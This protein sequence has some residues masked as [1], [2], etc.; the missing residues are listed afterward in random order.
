MTAWL[1]GGG[2]DVLPGPAL[3]G[4]VLPR[5]VRTDTPWLAGRRAAPQVECRLVASAADLV[6]HREIRRTVFV[7]EQ[8][9]FDLTDHDPRDDDPATLHVLGLVAGVPAGTVRLFPVDGARPG[10]PDWQGDRLAVL[11]AFRH[12]GLGAP[13]VR[14]AV[15]TAGALGGRRMLAHVQPPNRTFF[16]RLGWAQCGAPEIYV[17]LP[18]LRMEIDL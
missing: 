9:V 3:P 2:A 14:F 11:G 15:A 7:D 4:L 12:A 6:A 10:E 16:R 8:H 1:A 17:G 5:P 13:L 18:H